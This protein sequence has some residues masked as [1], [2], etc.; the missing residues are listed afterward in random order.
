MSLLLDAL[1]KAEKAKDDAKRRAGLAGTADADDTVRQVRTRN[2]LPDISKPLEMHPEDIPGIS[3]D[4]PVPDAFSTAPLTHIGL[5]HGAVL[6]RANVDAL[7]LIL[8]GDFALHEFAD[9][10]IDVA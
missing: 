9:L 10:A 8:G 2:E 7:E 1:K 6:R 5:E 4:N 3:A